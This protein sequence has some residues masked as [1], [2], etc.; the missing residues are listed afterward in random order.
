MDAEVRFYVTR[1]A[2]AIEAATT[3]DERA[4]ARSGAAPW[5]RGWTIANLVTSAVARGGTRQTHSYV[6]DG[7]GKRVSAYLADTGLDATRI[8]V[9]VAVAAHAASLVVPPDSDHGGKTFAATATRL[10]RCAAA[11]FAA[12]TNVRWGDR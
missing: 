1:A 12:S 10:A 9:L 4:A 2:Q 3:P 6:V 5:Q 11:D 8:R 7:D